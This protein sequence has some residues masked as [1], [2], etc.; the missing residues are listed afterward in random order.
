M[1][2]LKI[3][4]NYYLYP[5]EFTN[6]DSFMECINQDTNRFIP[7][8]QLLEDN[9]V[10]PY[11]IETDKVKCYINFKIVEKIS[12]SDITILSKVEYDYKLSDCISKT[13]LDCSN[14]IEDKVGDNL[15]GHRNKL[16]LDGQCDYKC[17]NS[18]E[19]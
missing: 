19:E 18:Y 4:Y 17:I 9:C 16:R 10:E 15:K 13:C 12:E 2:V 8:I 14:Y 6:L 7:L 5:N 3:G 1:K 11:F